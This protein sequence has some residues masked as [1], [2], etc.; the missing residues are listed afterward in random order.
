MSIDRA[1]FAFAGVMIIVSVLL[2]QFVHPMFVWFTLFI[3]ANLL[4]SAFSGWCPAAK[5][6]AKLGLPAGCAFDK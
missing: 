5:I 3:G 1:V 6:F 2:T 4:Q